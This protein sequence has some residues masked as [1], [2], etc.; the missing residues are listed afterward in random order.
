LFAKILI[1]VTL[2]IGLVY[3]YFAIKDVTSN[4]QP[5][6]YSQGGEL[7]PDWSLD[8]ALYRKRSLPDEMAAIAWLAEAPLGTVAEAVGGS[9]TDF[10]RV[11]T[12]SGQPTVLGWPGHQSQWRG[13]AAEMG[14]RESDI[15]LLY[16][17]GQWD[18][19]RTIL[20]QYGIRYVF[21]GDL[22]Y[23]K[24]NAS[25]KVFD[26][27]LTPLFVSGNVTIYGYDAVP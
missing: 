17:S 25:T 20:D 5:R 10:A 26:A 15:E 21:L 13:G 2:L 7:Q 16:R 4:F 3:P 18:T 27:Y 12:Y 23:S 11:S 14:T 22:E 1:V 9:Y 8:G 24:Y 6:I 19:V